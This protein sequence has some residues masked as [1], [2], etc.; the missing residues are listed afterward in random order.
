MSAPTTTDLT[1]QVRAALHKQFGAAL[2]PITDTDLLR[3]TLGDRYDSLAALEC[4]CRIE[5]EFGIEVDFVEH[6]VRHFFS[7][8]ELIGQFVGDQLEDLAVLGGSPVRT[9]ERA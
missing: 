5:A 4:I 3:E 8:I 9:P 2:D 6:D 7:T 1:E